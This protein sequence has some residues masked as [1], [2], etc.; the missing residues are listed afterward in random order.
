VLKDLAGMLRSFHYAAYASRPRRAD[1]FHISA[2]ES[3]LIERTYADVSNAFITKY[4]DSI[5]H[6]EL[7]PRDAEDFYA[8]LKLY[9]LRKVLYELQYELDHR[10]DWV[11]IPLKGIIGLLKTPGEI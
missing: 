8:L 10:P 2:R 11:G 9:L 6:K 1:F 7:L 3:A 5:E 4:V